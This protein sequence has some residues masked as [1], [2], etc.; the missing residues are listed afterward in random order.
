MLVHLEVSGKNIF[1]A[2]LDARCH[3]ATKVRKHHATGKQPLSCLAFG[4]TAVSFRLPSRLA[5]LLHSP[6]LKFTLD[7]I[8]CQHTINSLQLVGE[9]AEVLSVVHEYNHFSL[10]DSVVGFK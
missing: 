4:R 9:R 1:D 3:E 10:K 2:F 6:L 8:H 7:S 5:S